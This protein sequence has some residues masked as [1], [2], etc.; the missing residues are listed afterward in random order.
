[1]INVLVMGSK[2]REQ[3]SNK[4]SSVPPLFEEQLLS[5]PFLLA[6]LVV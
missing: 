5:N 2:D 4:H 6:F 3:A 1:M